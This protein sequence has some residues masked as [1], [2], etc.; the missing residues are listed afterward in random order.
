MPRRACLC[1]RSSRRGRADDGRAACVARAPARRP[2]RP[3]P[4][5]HGRVARALFGAMRIGAVPMPVNGRY[6]AR[7]LRTSSTRRHAPARR[8]PSG[9]SS[10]SSGLPA[11]RAGSSRA[12]TTPRSSAGGESVDPADVRPRSRPSSPTTALILYT[13]GTTANPKGCVLHA[14]GLVAQGRLRRRPLELTAED[15]FW[16]PLPFFHVGAHRRASSRPS[17]AVR[18][19]PRRRPLRPGRGARP[20]RA[21]ALHG[22]LPGLRDDLAARS[23]NHPRFAE[24]DLSALRLVDQRRRAGARCGRCRSGAPR[25][26]GLVLRRAPSPAVRSARRR[27]RPARGARRTTPGAR[28]RGMELRTSTPRPGEDCPPG[29]A[30]EFLFRGPTRVPPLL[31]RPGADGADD[32]RGRLV[33]H[34]R[35]R[36]R[37]RRTARIA[38]AAGS[39]T[40]SRSAARTSPRP[41]S[42]GYLLAPPGGRDRAGRRRAGRALRRGA[43]PRSSSSRRAPRSTEQRADRLLPRARSRRSRCRATC[44]SSTSGRCPARRSRSSR[45]ASGSRPSCASAGITEAPKLAVWLSRSGG[46]EGDGHAAVGR[47]SR[48]QVDILV[49]REERAD[50]WVPPG[51]A[52]SR[53]RPVG[54]SRRP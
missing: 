8:P 36:P 28:C 53:Q 21:R 1:G 22:R 15:R 19:R 47:H 16:T 5:R 41:R 45:C 25:P 46:A 24:A 2:H 29:D 38:F 11:S 27:R 23:S 52:G 13:S 54:S 3:A 40:C 4:R 33:P 18:A 31:P 12:S 42:R 26:A 43:A 39:R 14:R 34:R 7:E 32:R 17:S 48:Q 30:G 9:A 10:S 20:A 35:P 6:K 50:V 44:A 49:G 37:R 51:R